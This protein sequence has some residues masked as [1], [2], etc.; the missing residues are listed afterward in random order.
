MERIINAANDL[1]AAFTQWDIYIEYKRLTDKLAGDPA[2]LHKIEAFYEASADFE[3]RRRD[4]EDVNFEDEKSLSA[5]YTDIWL[6][7]SGR[8]YMETRRKLHEALGKIFEVIE[9]DCVL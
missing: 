8:L 7:E 6:N 5:R 2:L 9:R 3:R 4:G 1:A